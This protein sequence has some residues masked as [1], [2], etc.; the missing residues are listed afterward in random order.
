MTESLNKVL[1]IGHI[2]H[3][4]EFRITSSGFRVLNFNLATN[5]RYK[6]RNGEWQDRTEWHYIVIW[7]KRGESLSRVLKKGSYVFIEGRLQTRQWEDQNGNKRLTT[8]IVATDLRFL[9]G[10]GDS[11]SRSAPRDDGQTTW[12]REHLGT[13]VEDDVDGDMPF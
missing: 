2:G 10:R 7:G 1:L 9:G 5:E 3:N 13:L 12:E 11:E 6:N 4:P 8:E